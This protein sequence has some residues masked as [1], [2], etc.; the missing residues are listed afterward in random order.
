MNIF[1]IAILVS[2]SL[3][4]FFDFVKKQTLGYI[5]KPTTTLLIIILAIIQPAGSDYYRYFIIAG[6][7]FSLIGD[8]SLMLPSDKFVLGLGA[9]LVAL[10]FYILAFS[11]GFGPYFEIWYL[12]PVAIYAII[13]LWFVLPKTGKMKLPVLIYVLVLI[14]FMWQAT[15]MYYYLSQ[16]SA[17]YVFAGAILFVISDSILAYDR[18][19]KTFRLSSA[20]IHLTYW[21]AQILLALSI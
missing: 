10:I 6:L 17:L 1:I 18:F 11:S 16:S 3:Y 12:I 5:F 14:V 4:I 13:F 2:A 21:C 19:V 8:I 9:F 20:I 15:G 7:T